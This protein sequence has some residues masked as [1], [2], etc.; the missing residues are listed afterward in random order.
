MKDGLS[1]IIP[2]YNEEKT[3]AASVDSACAAAMEAGGDFE[4][5]VVN[6]CSKDSTATVSSELALANPRV[7]ALSNPTNLGMGGAFKTGLENA[8]F[9][10]AMVFPA[11]NE[12]PVVGVL[13]IL[14]ARGKADIII[15]YVT[16]PEIR[17]RH[18]RVISWCYVTL[19]NLLFGQKI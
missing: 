4:I 3:L 17:A 7:R 14:L 6:D 1:I 2:A 10:H 5:L 11:D 18:R 13:P 12:H 8:A 19:V 15:P 16:N 9:S